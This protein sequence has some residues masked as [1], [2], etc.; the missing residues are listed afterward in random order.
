MGFLGFARGAL[1]YVHQNWPGAARVDF[2]VEQKQ[3]ISHHLPDYRDALVDW[4]TA[5]QQSSL[6]ELLGKLTA[7]DKTDVPLQAADLAMWHIR[8][9]EAGE[10]RTPKTF[11]DCV[12]CS[13]GE[14]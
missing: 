10:R 13:T 9:R 6:L 14:R 8:R 1:E 2:V 7:G 11:S 12:R 4:L 3:G 5:Q